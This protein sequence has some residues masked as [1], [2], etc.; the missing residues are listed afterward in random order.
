MK[1][2]LT[3][4][5]IVIFLSTFI[6]FSQIRIV[7]ATKIIYYIDINVLN[8][9]KEANA[10]VYKIKYDYNS[11]IEYLLKPNTNT[12]TVKYFNISKNARIHFKDVKNIFN[13]DVIM[14]VLS[15]LATLILFKLY[16]ANEEYSFLLYSSR[17][18]L[19]ICLLFI[20]LFSVNFDKAF[21]A[22]HKLLFTNSYWLF[23][24]KADSI[25]NILPQQFFL[26]CSL[27]MIFLIFFW[28]ILLRLIYFKI[29]PSKK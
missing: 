28:G 16:K 19:A 2:K 22:M 29:K 9:P 12:L 4:I 7:C 17:V 24:E 3:C 11:I 23:D 1:G 6:F 14:I 8:I 25:I 26:H 13:F 27:A 5:L 10:S 21:T 20:V 18:L 15:L